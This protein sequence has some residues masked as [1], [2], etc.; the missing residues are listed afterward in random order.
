MGDSQ[1]SFPYNRLMVDRVDHVVKLSADF[2]H[3]LRERGSEMS[4][5]VFVVQNQRFE[6]HRVVLAA[7]CPYFKAMLY[8][9]M[10]ESRPNVEI[11]LPDATADSFRLLMEYAYTGC[12]DLSSLRE[13][14][15]FFV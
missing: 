9:G 13:E 7:R 12:L 3:L 6:C 4:D 8:G 1:A 2:K 11:E 10:R 14:V 5:V 15:S